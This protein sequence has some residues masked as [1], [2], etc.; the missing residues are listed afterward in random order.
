VILNSSVEPRARSY[1]PKCL[2]KI[3][4]K[5]LLEKQIDI[6]KNSFHNPN[7]IVITG[8]KHKKIYNMLKNFSKV[9][10]IENKIFEETNDLYS[11]RLIINNLSKNILLLQGNI[12]IQN[13]IFK[14][15]QKSKSQIIISKKHNFELGCIINTNNVIENV[16]WSLPEYWTNIVFFKGNEFILLKKIVNNEISTKWFLFEGI[17]WVIENGGIFYS[18][19]TKSK[20]INI[21]HIQNAKL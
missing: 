14:N 18:N 13:K 10:I 8:F 11:I 12:F 9:Q 7:I 15:F 2:L 19:I 21:N 1:D 16:S 20:V 5:T 6:L 3:G 17:N 4:N